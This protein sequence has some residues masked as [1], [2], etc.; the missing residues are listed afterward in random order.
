MPDEF[1]TRAEMQSALHIHREEVKQALADERGQRV[2]DFSRLQERV[3]DFSQALTSISLGMQEVGRLTQSVNDLRRELR[4]DS[5]DGPES[6]WKSLRQLQQLSVQILD[7]VDENQTWIKNEMS[8]RRL[9]NRVV[10]A[11]FQ[12]I[13]GRWRFLGIASMGILSLIVAL[14]AGR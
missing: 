12:A 1:V 6:V 13:I 14:V 4:G 9:R 3:D 10:S 7:K 2:A 11:A 8:M 5:A